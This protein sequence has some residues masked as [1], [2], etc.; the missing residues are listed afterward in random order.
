LELNDF[1]TAAA[2]FQLPMNGLT[3]VYRFRVFMGNKSLN[4]YS[5]T[6]FVEEYKRPKFETSFEYVKGVCKINDSVSVKGTAK[7]L[8]G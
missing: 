7:A 2:K 8:A 6:I 4:V 1:G 5:G 3:G